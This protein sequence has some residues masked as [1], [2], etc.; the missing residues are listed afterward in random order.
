MYRK[1]NGGEFGIVGRQWLDW[2]LKGDRKAARQ[3]TGAACGLCKDS[4]WTVQKK[5]LQ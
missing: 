2:Q 3:F 1:P 5:N 4:R